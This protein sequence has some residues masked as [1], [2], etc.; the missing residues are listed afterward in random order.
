MALKREK[1]TVELDVLRDGW[2][3]A[4]DVI[5]D[6]KRKAVELHGPTGARNDE[7]R[8]F[9]AHVNITDRQELGLDA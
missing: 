8:W 3:A 5:K 9:I 7:P 2:L 4:D 6:L 1:V